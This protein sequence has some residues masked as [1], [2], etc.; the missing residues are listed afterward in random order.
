MKAVLGL[1]LVCLVALTQAMVPTNRYMRCS[2]DTDC[3]ASQCCMDI[4]INEQVFSCK[5]IGSH[6]APCALDGNSR[7]FCP[8]ELGLTCRPRDP[9]KWEFFIARYYMS[10]DE[11]SNLGLCKE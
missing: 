6:G 11:L 1:F 5:E 7:Y 8:C 9:E 4:G 2:A 10:K 3:K